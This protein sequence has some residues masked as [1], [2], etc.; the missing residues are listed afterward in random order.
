ME[1]VENKVM[2]HYHK[3]YIKP[4]EWQIGN[5]LIIDSNYDSEFIH[6]S[7]YNNNTCFWIN[8][9][10]C[11]SASLLAEKILNKA[12]DEYIEELFHDKE[13]YLKAMRLLKKYVEET[14][15]ML[16]NT[17]ITNREEG[18]EDYRAKNHPDYISRLH[19]LWVCEEKQLKYWERMLNKKCELYQILLTGN[20]QRTNAAYL[21]FFGFSREETENVSECYWNPPEGRDES[22]DE[23]LFQGKAKILR[24]VI[25]EK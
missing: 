2:Y 3:P 12:T 21:P 20:L 10:E 8:D 15:G 25:I 18:L 24:K 19:C 4:E 7:I 22:K 23:F 1:K 14:G 5:E 9:N 13:K 16:R 6:G 17:A 11:L